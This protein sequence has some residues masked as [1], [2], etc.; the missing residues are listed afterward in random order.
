MVVAYVLFF[1]AGV[2]FGYAALGAWRWAPLAFP[3]LLALVAVLQEGL[4]ATL[5]L[6]L[7]AALVVTA[8]GVVAGMLLDRGE[9]PRVA[10][11]GWR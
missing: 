8:L 5:L 9:P 1:L 2:G 6:R 10:Q 4:D 7:L 11:P 3:V